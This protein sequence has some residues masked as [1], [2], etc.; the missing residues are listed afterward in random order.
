M[1]NILNRIDLI[2]PPM[3]HQFTCKGD[4]SIIDK[5]NS[6]TDQISIVEL[7]LGLSCNADHGRY[8]VFGHNVMLMIPTLSVTS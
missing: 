7:F 3:M 5:I 1:T 4:A 8:M 2:D 6:M